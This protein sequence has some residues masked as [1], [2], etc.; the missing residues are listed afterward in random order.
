IDARTL[1]EGTN[2]E[3][4][5]CI[6]GGGAAGITLARDLAGGGRKIIMLE[7]GGFEFSEKTQELYDGA[8][9]GQPLHPLMVERL[10]F[11]GGSTNHWAGGCRPFDAEDF[12]VRV[13]VP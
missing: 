13:Y 9:V 10:R 8:T 2:L 6:I 5:V 12:S 1:P 4:D 7:S 3:A 11:F